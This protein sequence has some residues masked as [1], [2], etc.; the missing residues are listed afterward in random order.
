V[1][2]LAARV[3]WNVP[4]GVTTARSHMLSRC[5]ARRRPHRRRG[6]RRPHAHRA[7]EARSRVEQRTPHEPHRLEREG[8]LRPAGEGGG[9]VAGALC[10]RDARAAARRLRGEQLVP[11]QPSRV[12]VREGHHRG[13]CGKRSALCA[14]QLPLRDPPSRRRDGETHDRVVWRVPGSAAGA[15]GNRVAARSTTRETD[16]RVLATPSP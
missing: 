15:P 6:L 13:P 12:A 2:R 7:A 5:A 16:R 4:A 14:A 11:L 10:F 8:A 9:G 3:R 1:T